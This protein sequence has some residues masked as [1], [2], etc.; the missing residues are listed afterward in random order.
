[1]RFPSDSRALAL[2]AGSVLLL[3]AAVIAISQAIWANV[4][5]SVGGSLAGQT[6]SRGE[7][8]RILEESSDSVFRVETFDCSQH[9]ISTG[10]G[11]LIEE[12]VVTNQHVVEDA[13]LI[14]LTNDSGER[15][16]IVSWQASKDRDLALLQMGSHRAPALDLLDRNP[17]PG[18]LVATIGYPLGE[19]LSIRDGRIFSVVDGDEYGIDGEFFSMTSEAL[20]GDSGGPVISSEGKVVGVTTYLLYK[21]NLSVAIPVEDLRGFLSDRIELATTKPCLVD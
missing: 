13:A 7:W 2:V 1:L 18:A 20:S 6:I 19:E 5:S 17:I 10:T 14:R 3:V 11:F 21:D 4:E 16:D 15:I 8:S 9:P 12:G